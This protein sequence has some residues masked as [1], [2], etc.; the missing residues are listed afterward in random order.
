M[1]PKI[2]S[3]TDMRRW[4][5]YTIKHHQIDALT[6]MERAATAFCNWF[7]NEYDKS[8]SIT[9]FCGKGNNGGDGFV[10]ARLLI[11][12]GYTVQVYA[13]ANSGL[14]NEAN[15]NFNRLLDLNVPVTLIHDNFNNIIVGDI[16]IDAILGTGVN[17]PISGALLSLVEYINLQQSTVIAVD[18]PSGLFTEKPQV[19]SAIKANTTIAFERPKKAFMIPENYCYVGDWK[20]IPIGLVAAF[21]NELNEHWFLITE[22]YVIKSTI[23]RKRI[24]HKGTYG[25]ALLIGGST[26]KFG[27]L[28]LASKAAL[29]SGC[30]LV[31]VSSAE[32]IGNWFHA[33]FPEAMILANNNINNTSIK[34]IGIGPGF[35]TSDNAKALL[36]QI[37]ALNKP[38]VIDA[39]AINLLAIN[40][41]L[42]PQL[43]KNSI[44]TPHPKELER[45][46]GAFKSWEDRLNFLRSWCKKHQ[47][48][49]ICKNAN[50]LIITPA[51]EIFVNNTGCNGMAT[52]GS[53]DVL[54]GIIT[55]MLA[56]GYN[57]V[58]AAI[59]AVYYHGF[60]GEVAS[61]K[62]GN[63]GC[64]A[65]DIIEEI[66]VVQKY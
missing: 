14:S 32:H 2:V 37:I 20:V 63:H 17:R 27:A 7:I 21:E 18:V 48:I 66:G 62:H 59:R 11:N 53:G 4:D 33:A 24:D 29:K 57:P 41:D 6:L 15:T 42:I 39:D 50:T 58:N 44:L 8:K 52:A 34:S 49:M 38:M 28:V 65:S 40:Q 23:K 31:S 60:A 25:H 55:S 19:G 61:K 36:K 1:L 45:L 13:L 30:G 12:N 22:E 51:Q 26:G 9:F 3:A 56:Q 64:L 47:L 10:I 54:T 35:G 5:A 43:P 16:I 46:I